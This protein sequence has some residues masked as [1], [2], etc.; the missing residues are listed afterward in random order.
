M[1]KTLFGK[2]ANSGNLNPE[3]YA[4]AKKFDLNERLIDFAV[5]VIDVSEVLPRTVAGNHIAGQLVRSGTSPALNYGEAQ[6]AESR[7][8]FIRKLKIS[9]K[10]LRETYN[11]LRIIRRKKWYSEEKLAPLLNE[12]N[13]LISIFCKS[14]ETARKNS[15]KE[16]AASASPQ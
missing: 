4:M 9:T 1:G 6:S 7:K 10:E 3:P 5:G 8:D 12:N 2:K 15:K 13:Q 14:A 16:I 11:C